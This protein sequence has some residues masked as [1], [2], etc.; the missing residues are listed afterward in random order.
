MIVMFM[1]HLYPIPIFIRIKY[2]HDILYVNVGFSSCFQSPWSPPWGLEQM[3]KL[4]TEI[5]SSLKDHL[6]QK[7][8]KPLWSLE[9]PG[10]ADIQ[11]PRSKTPRRGRRYTSSERD[12]TKAREAH[13]RAL[14]TVAALE[15]KTE[16]L[17]QSITQGW[18][19]ICAHSES[20]DCQRRRSWGWN[21]RHHRVWP[22]ESPASFFKYSPPW[23]GPGSG[24]DEE[25]ELPILDFNLEPPPELGPEVDH[26]LQEPAGSLEEDDRSRSS[27]EPPVEDYERWV[28]WQTRAHDTPGWWPDLAQIPGV[29]NHQELAQKVQ[30]SFELPWQISEQ[31]G[32][33]NY[34]QAP[35][36]PLCILPEGLPP[37][38]WSK[39]PLLGH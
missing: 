33:E 9:E 36:T 37:T 17:S 30:A 1:F 31:H 38:A 18:P 32:M 29:D 23:W 2:K 5:V 7:E 8:G 27:A 12:L 13:W 24:E 25:A 19:D 22:E 10:P 26:F 34:H 20:Q 21:R 14:A 35:P 28:T 11:P 39:V 16:K 6:G 3:E 15:E 4:A